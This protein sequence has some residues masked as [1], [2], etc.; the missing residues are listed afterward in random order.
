M[1]MIAALPLFGRSMRAAGH[2][3]G[4]IL[5]AVRPDAT[6]QME[7]GF[8]AQ[9]E[10]R[11]QFADEF[12]QSGTGTGRRSRFDQLIDGLNRLPRPLLAFGT[13][14]L[15]VDAMVA[16]DAFAL[17]MRGLAQVPDPLWWLL[18]A[19]VSFYFGARELD[20]ARRTRWMSGAAGPVG[21]GSAG[22]QEPSIAPRA[23]DGNPALEEWRQS[24]DR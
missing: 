15:F 4:G 14:G 20:Y 10:A 21:Q 12:R 19:I 16:P 2:A 18:G 11:T 1:G 5:R 24:R 9:K 22:A 23:P 7:L 3:V 13:I 17:R 6:R 8:E